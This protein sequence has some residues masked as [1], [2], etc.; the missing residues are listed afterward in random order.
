[1]DS[2][3]EEPGSAV[4]HVLLAITSDRGLCG[5][6]NSSI[7]KAIRNWLAENPD[8]ADSSRIIAVGDKARAQL[9]RSYGNKMLMHFAEVG[10]VPATFQNASQVAEKLMTSDFNFDFATMYY[11]VFK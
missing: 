2:K 9:Q 6:A 1:M 8:K 10:K 3:T 11:N 7:T 4:N 5:A